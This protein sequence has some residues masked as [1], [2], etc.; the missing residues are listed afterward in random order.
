MK[1][2]SLRS[3]A[4]T[5]AAFLSLCATS[6]AQDGPRLERVEVRVTAVLGELVY[7]DRGADA[8]LAVGDRVTLR[9]AGRTPLEAEL[10]LVTRASSRATLLGEAGGLAVGDLGDVL[11]PAARP[12]TVETDSEIVW[13]HPAEAFD[14]TR[15]LLGPAAH[16][17]PAD[18]P[19]TLRGRAF[20]GFDF[21]SDREDGGQDAWLART[22]FDATLTNPF[23]RGGWLDARV[24]V[25]GRR[26]EL[27]EG[28]EDRTRLRID[29]LAYRVGGTR[30]E[31]RAL[32]I[33]RFQHGELPELGRID[34]V[35]VVQRLSSGDRLGASVGFLPEPFAELDTGD[36]LS[37]AVFYRGFLGERAELSYAGAFQKTWHRGDADRDL[38]L[39]SLDWS[40][41]SVFALHGSA[42]VDLYGSGSASK[43]T[44]PELS[45]AHFAANWRFSGER[46]FGLSATHVRWPEIERDEFPEPSLADLSD[47]EVTRLGAHAYT[48]LSERMRLRV[49]GDLWEDQDQS[50]MGGEVEIARG[51]SGPRYRELALALFANDAKFVEVYGARLALR[52]R[53]PRSGWR[54]GYEAAL[55]DNAGDFDF[56]DAELQHLVRAGLDR[57]F[58]ADWSLALDGDY[59]FGDDQEGFALGL[60][61]TRRF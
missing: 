20:V 52:E 45:E 38:L 47:A 26:T 23:G 41:G 61:L 53:G 19:R 54:L 15:P 42:W 13:R 17:P 8:R 1:V 29:R 16:T 37:A 58:D 30:D 5:C 12:S 57:D 28:T 6:H 35:E 27:D 21:F 32:S 36:D 56:G 55:F 48:R 7:L 2:R 51:G 60:F 4:W 14:P 24:E 39:A 22:G 46:G 59:R 9:P 34:G 25:F 49:R 31:A 18:R 10:T 11:V 33:G 40:P 44:G 3:L 43:D 50:G